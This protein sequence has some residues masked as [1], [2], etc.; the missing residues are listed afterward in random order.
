MATMQKTLNLD[1]EETLKQL[2][3]KLWNCHSSI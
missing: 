1:N 3:E 2:E